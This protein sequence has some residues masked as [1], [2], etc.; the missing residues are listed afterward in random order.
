MKQFDVTDPADP[1]QVGSVR[2]GGIVNRTAHPARPDMPLSG[3]PQMVEVSR[4]G[5]RDTSPIAVRGVGRPVL[6]TAS[7][8]GWSS[9]PTPTAD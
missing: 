9:T 7:A 1:K 2:L 4:D 5:K 6:P 3:G 8:P